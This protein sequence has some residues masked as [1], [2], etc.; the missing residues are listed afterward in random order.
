MPPVL[1]IAAA[2][3]LVLLGIILC[4]LTRPPRTREPDAPPDEFPEAALT[5]E[6]AART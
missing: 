6:P 5:S 3:G 4:F 1:W 2:A